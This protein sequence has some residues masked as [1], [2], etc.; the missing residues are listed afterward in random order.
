[1]FTD[2]CI[3]ASFNAI[4]GATLQGTIFLTV[5]F[6]YHASDLWTAPM[7]SRQDNVVSL[8]VSPDLTIFGFDHVFS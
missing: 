3:Q 4:G 5:P 2:S 6:R 1:M 8:L 7:I